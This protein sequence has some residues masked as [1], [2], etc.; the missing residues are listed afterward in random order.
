MLS[1]NQRMPSDPRVSG[2]NETNNRKATSAL[3]NPPLQHLWEFF[4]FSFIAG[5]AQSLQKQSVD[6]IIHSIVLYHHVKM[7]VLTVQRRWGKWKMEERVTDVEQ[8]FLRLQ[9]RGWM[10]ISGQERSQYSSG[11]YPP[12]IFS[13]TGKKKGLARYSFKNVLYEDAQTERETRFKFEID[14]LIDYSSS[15]HCSAML[16]QHKILWYRVNIYIGP[17]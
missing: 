7:L 12:P 2:Q 15:L 5:L 11:R 9:V 6:L 17:V 3:K 4:A 13:Y 8:F 16:V 1:R 14:W 10:N